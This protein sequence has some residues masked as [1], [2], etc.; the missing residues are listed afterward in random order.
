ML[1]KRLSDFI[2]LGIIVLVI[3]AVVVARFFLLGVFDDRIEEAKE[4]NE[5]LEIELL[6]NQQ[7][8]SDYRDDVL[9][10]EAE[11]HRAMPSSYSYT[12]LRN[13]VQGHLELEG[14]TA[15]AHRDRSVE[16]N[17]NAAIPPEAALSEYA[18][19]YDA[20]GI[21]IRFN[22]DDVS[23]AADV[24]DRLYAQDQLFVLHS[25]EYETGG[26]SRLDLRFITFYH[27]QE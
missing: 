24:V 23:E 5:D 14:I 17:E 7:L 10:S 8:I 3:I 25:V 11:L 1:S 2:F 20:V 21:R 22:T 15:E 26:T 6:E 18:G 4:T 27:L 19:P 16:I 13:K 12:R 9:P